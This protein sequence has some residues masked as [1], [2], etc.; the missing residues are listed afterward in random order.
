MKKKV[1]VIGAGAAGL[2]AAAAA[3][4]NG[5]DVTVL[6]KNEKAIAFYQRHGFRTTGERKPEEGTAEYLVRMER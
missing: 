5:H 2:M 3:A 6:E 1:I 4:E